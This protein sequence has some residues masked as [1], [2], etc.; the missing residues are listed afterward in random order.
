M[1]FFKFHSYYCGLLKSVTTLAIVSA[2]GLSACMEKQVAPDLPKT[3]MADYTTE[4]L[5]EGL[6]TPW[7]FASLP[8]GGFLITERGGTLKRVQNGETTIITGLPDDIFVGN[9]AGLFDVML[10]ADFVE[11]NFLYLSYARGT[12]AENGTAVIVAELDGDKLI[13]ISEVFTA[14]PLKSGAAHFGGSLSFLPG[15]T[16]ALST[17]DGFEFREAA[18]DRKSDLGKII[19]LTPPPAQNI[20]IGHRNVQGLFFDPFTNSLW[21]HEHGPRGGDELN[22]IQPGENYGWPIVS[23][24]LDYNGAKITPLTEM[25]GMSDPVHV[26]TPSIAPSGLII[27]RGGMFPE[28]NGDA[29]VGGLASRDVRRVDLENGIAVG[30]EILFSDI[31]A[32]VRDVDMGFDGSL[33]VLAVDGENSRLIRFI[34]KQD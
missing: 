14:N 25:A 21:A 19:K 32:R 6:D 34:P 26:W 2:V 13:N 27:Y 33:L 9:Q 20:S 12:E 23:Q 7:A 11:N 18:Q 8:G 30:E 1:S 31:N 22:L 15:G 3:M 24:G 29:I 5:A 28:W 10:S 4:V 17:G 16:V